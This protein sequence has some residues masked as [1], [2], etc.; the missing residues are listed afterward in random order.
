MVFSSCMHFLSTHACVCGCGC[1]RFLNINIFC[2][3]FCPSAE[4]FVRILCDGK[5]STRH[6]SC[7]VSLSPTHFLRS[8][9]SNY[10]CVLWQ[11]IE[12]GARAR[13]ERPKQLHH[14]S[15]ASFF[16]NTTYRMILFVFFFVDFLP[17][18]LRQS[19]IVDETMYID[20]LSYVDG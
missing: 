12:K 10:I 6:S 11:M 4:F 19:L 13:R 16:L 8:S 17:R 20:H 9:I 5:S 3:F 14:N 15:P 18:S 2:P 7:T 1:A